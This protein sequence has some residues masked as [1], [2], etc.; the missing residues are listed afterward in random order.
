MC[1]VI[2]VILVIQVL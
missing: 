1:R 2:L